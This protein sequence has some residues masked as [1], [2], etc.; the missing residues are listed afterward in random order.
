MLCD[1]IGQTLLFTVDHEY[2]CKKIYFKAIRK[3]A[4]MH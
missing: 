2:T 3:K 4:Y 1:K